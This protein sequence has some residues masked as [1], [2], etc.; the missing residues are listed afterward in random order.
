MLQGKNKNKE[1]MMVGSLK[2]SK[3]SKWSSVALTKLEC[4][5]C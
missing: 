4:H 5:S 3:V 2:N 1:N